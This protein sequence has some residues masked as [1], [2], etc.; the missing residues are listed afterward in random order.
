MEEEEMRELLQAL[1]SRAHVER[2]V[3]AV[4]RAVRVAYPFVHCC[5]G[6]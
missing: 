3:D 1:R 2:K 6:G 4:Q 5:G